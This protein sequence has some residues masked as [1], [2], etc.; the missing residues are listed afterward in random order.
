MYEY[1]AFGK[2]INAYGDPIITVLSPFRYR[3]YVYDMETGLYYLQSRYYDPVTGRFLNAD[4]TAFVGAKGTAL[5]FNLFSYCEN[6]PITN[7]DYD[8]HMAASTAAAS[9]ATSYGLSLGG[10][11]LIAKLSAFLVTIAPYLLIAI[12]VVVVAYTAYIIA[13][14]VSIRNIVNKIPNK[15]K[16]KV[17]LKKFNKK[18][19]NG[20]GWKG[21]DGWKIV[22][23]VAK[24]AGSAWKLLNKAGKRIATLWEDGSVR[25]K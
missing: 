9:F 22:K 20:G 11:A 16:T 3:G 2:I 6:N 21:P 7:V 24:H 5:S 14:N 4:D 17:D 18:L 15:L 12:A 13:K 19:P 25:G 23:D 8:G 10:A 1:D